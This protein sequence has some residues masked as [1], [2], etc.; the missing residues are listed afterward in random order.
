MP[1]FGKRSSV[2]WSTDGCGSFAGD[3][4]QCNDLQMAPLN[5]G[6]QIIRENKDKLM[7][8]FESKNTAHIQD[9]IQMLL[10]MRGIFAILLTREITKLL[11]R[12]RIMNAIQGKIN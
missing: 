1:Y 3:F 11:Y 10:W 7:Q 5:I 12:D 6:Q 8:M 9:S 2:L 4:S